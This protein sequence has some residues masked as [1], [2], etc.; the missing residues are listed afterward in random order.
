MSNSQPPIAKSDPKITELHGVSLLDN[1]AWMRNK[2]DPEV[3]KYLKA[4]NEYTNH[5]MKHTEEFQKILFEEF[6]SR[7]KEDDTTVPYK[8]GD[9]Y[10]YT[11]TEKDKNYTIHCRKLKSLDSSEIIILDQNKEAGDSEFYQVR[12]VIPSP[13]HKILAYSEDRSGYETFTIY[14]K[15]LETGE[16]LDEKIENCSG[17]FQWSKDGSAIY[18]GEYDEIHRGFTCS[19]HFLNSSQSED[20][21]LFEEPDNKYLVYFYLT[22]DENYLMIYSSGQNSNE[23]YYIDQNNDLTK[24]QQLF[25]RE[26]K[27]EYSIDHK[28]GY[29]YIITNVDA[30]N[31]RLVKTQV[32]NSNRDNWEELIP[33]DIKVRLSSLICFK[34]FMVIFKRQNGY[35]SIGILD[36]ATKTTH[37]LKTPEDACMLYPGNNVDYYSDR[38]RF[39]YMSLKTPNT[40]FDYI[41][42][43]QKLEILKVQEVNNFDSDNY[44]AERIYAKARD[45]TEI[46]ISLVYHKDT[47]LNSNTPLLLYA[48]GSYGFPIDPSFQTHRISLLERGFVFA[49]AHIRGGGEYGKP[50]YESGKMEHKMNTFTD[51]IDCAENLIKENYT[52]PQKLAAIGGSAGG[53]LMGVISNLRPDL[54]QSIIALVPF[55]DVI[56]T[57]MDASIPLTTFEYK[58]WGNPE[59]E[60]QFH[61]MY[62]YSPYDN[63]SEQKYPNILI[64]GG[65]NDPRVHF[66]EPSKWIAKLRTMNKSDKKLLLKMDLDS[67]HGGKSGRYETMKETAFHYSFI[68][69]TLGLE[70][71]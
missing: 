36:Y 57:M 64:T 29:F 15:N 68:F 26:E 13:D 38:L 59:I 50:W 51:F 8:D 25:K 43:D 63:V 62:K 18:Y 33:H 17:A 19:V 28:D 32:V 58:E 61:W 31:F 67:G 55:V 27:I 30:I 44:L 12:M 1:Y 35:T 45:S 14:F 10:Y 22:H 2:E 16:I 24:V 53:L 56:N 65:L 46:P 6:R 47:T 70:L 21:R 49:I 41:V 4:E 54:F 11:R 71:K 40:V 60:E 3:I 7:I 9:Y 20:K 34:D 5:E 23:I 52:S 69:E 37:E 39:N 66:W 42:K 48:Y